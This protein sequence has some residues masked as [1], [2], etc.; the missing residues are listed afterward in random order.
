VCPA[1]N[2]FRSER[3][4]A[5][6]YRLRGESWER[7]LARL[8]TLGHRAAVVGPRGHGKTTLLDA[9]ARRLAE[10][11][12]DVVRARIEHATPLRVSARE[13]RGRT[14]LLDGTETLGPWRWRRLRARL[15]RARGLIVSRHTSGALPAWIHCETDPALLAELFA[16]LVHGDPART[17]DG[18]ERRA[19]DALWERHAGNLR[20]C[21]LDLYHRF[22]A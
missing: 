21:L 4:D 15:A 13:A 11:G 2:P 18:G 16:E 12:H 17:L 19:L 1:D 14:F 10:R 22:A 3:I 20:S 5:L 6:A 8:D 7:A 9:L